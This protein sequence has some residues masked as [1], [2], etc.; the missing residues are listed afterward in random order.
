MNRPVM[1]WNYQDPVKFSQRVENALRQEAA[2]E[3][4]ELEYAKETDY[5]EPKYHGIPADVV[6][7]IAQASQSS[8]QTWDEKGKQWQRERDERIKT[9]AKREKMLNRRTNKWLHD[10]KSDFDKGG[11]DD[12]QE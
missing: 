7:R 6:K 4:A 1:K 10:L 8:E 9:E 5:F 3:K 2:F 12:V 11:D